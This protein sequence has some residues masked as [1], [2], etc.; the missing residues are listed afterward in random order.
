MANVVQRE[1]MKRL[2]WLSRELQMDVLFEAH[3]R[4]EI[5]TIPEGA[6]I[7]GINSRKF[8]ASARWTLTRFLLALG[9]GGSSQRSD[10]SV[11]LDTFSLIKHVPAQAIKVAES[12]LSPAK[13]PEIK[14]MGYNA[15]LVGTSLL[16]AQQGMEKIMA[17]FEA[18]VARANNDAM[19]SATL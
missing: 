3:T 19:P 15:V 10:F 6:K 9:L 2:F 18:A 1:R 17:E 4:E 8:Q 16:N 13:I 12:G 11:E 14:Q 5:E 7:Y